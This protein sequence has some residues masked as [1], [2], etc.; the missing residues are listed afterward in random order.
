MKFIANKSRI[1]PLKQIA[2]PLLE[3]CGAVLHVK[4]IHKVKDA[5]RIDFASAHLWSDSTI[6]PSKKEN[7][8]TLDEVEAAETL[9]IINEQRS[10]KNNKAMICN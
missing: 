7:L 4:L 8:L 10:L 5:L 1:S 9:A 3:L 6:E 2:I